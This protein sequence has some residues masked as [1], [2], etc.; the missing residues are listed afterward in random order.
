MGVGVGETSRARPVDE[1]RVDGVAML[2]IQ[3]I[4]VVSEGTETSV[5]R[6]TGAML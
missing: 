2:V 3:V 6:I 4:N 5:V 1:A